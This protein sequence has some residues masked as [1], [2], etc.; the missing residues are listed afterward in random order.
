[1]THYKY[2]YKYTSRKSNKGI[3]KMLFEHFC[4]SINFFSRIVS[5]F[6]YHIKIT[7]KR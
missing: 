6:M 4:H 7:V 3:S 2:V 1:M 5:L